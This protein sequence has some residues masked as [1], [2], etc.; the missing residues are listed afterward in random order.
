MIEDSIC[1][2]ERWRAEMWVWIGLLKKFF[3]GL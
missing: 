2:I 3:G 1:S